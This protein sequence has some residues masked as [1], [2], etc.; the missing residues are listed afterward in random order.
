M[1]SS[2]DPL[3]FSLQH[4]LSE[5]LCKVFVCFSFLFHQKLFYSDADLSVFP[6]EICQDIQSHRDYLMF[7]CV[8]SKCW[9]KGTPFL[10]T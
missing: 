4:L 7:A 6:A 9:Q 8:G 2:I 5:M 10:A 3:T 1:F